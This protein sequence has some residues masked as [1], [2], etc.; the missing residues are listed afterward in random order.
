MPYLNEQ[1]RHVQKSLAFAVSFV[2]L[3]SAGYAK[4][5]IYDC[6]FDKGNSK[7]WIAQQIVISHDVAAGTAK[8]SDGIILQQLDQP[9]DGEVRVL[10][11][12]RIEFAWKLHDTRSVSGQSAP[13]FAYR[14][15]YNPANN[16]ARVDAKPLGYSD[17]FQAVGSCKAK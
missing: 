5:V 10:T 4:P 6:A 12:G 13:T 17:N 16:K 9:I 7:G 15:K 1:E 11:D 3:A 14:L 2:M 8:I